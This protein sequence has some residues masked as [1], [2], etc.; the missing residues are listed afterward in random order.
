MQMRGCAD[1]EGYADA[2]M[3]NAPPKYPD[4]KAAAPCDSLLGV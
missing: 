4:E 1:E 3:T 2:L